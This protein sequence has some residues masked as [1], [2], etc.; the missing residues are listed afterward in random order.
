MGRPILFRCPKPG[1]NVQQWLADEAPEEGAGD[2]K[3][4]TCP[5]CTRLH[6][7]HSATGKLLGDDD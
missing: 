4:V 2:Y 7:I 1:M 3:A 6:F 5:A